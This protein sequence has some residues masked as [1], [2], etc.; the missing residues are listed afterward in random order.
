MAEN[1]ENIRLSAE[2]ISGGDQESSPFGFDFVIVGATGDLTM[3]KLLPAFYERFR[4]DQ[5]D[6]TT[7]IIGTARSPLSS[8]EYRTKAAEALKAFV[9]AETYDASKAEAFLRLLHYVPLDMTEQNADWSALS[10]LLK[11]EKGRP[12]V[13]YLATAPKLY[14][15]TADAIA[16]NSLITDTTRI[17]LEKPIGTDL[18]SA[19]AINDGVGQHFRENQIFRIDHYLGKQTVQNIL[20]LRFANPIIERIWNADSIAHVQITASETVGVGQRGSYY[21][22]AGALRDMVQNHLLQ[23]LSFVAMEPPTAIAPTVLRDE[24][25]KILRALRP[26]TDDMIRTDTVRAQYAAGEVDGT[27]VGSYLDDLEDGESTTETYLAIR[28]EIRTA[29][30]A[31]VPFYIR[32]GKRLAQKETTVIVQF[33]PQPWAIFPDKPEPGRLVIRIQPNEGISL[34]LSSKDPSTEQFCLREASLDVSYEKAFNTRY[35][36]SYEDLLMAAVRG[37]QVSFIRRDEVEAS[38]H[39]VEPILN[40]W[41]ANIRPLETYPAGSRGPKSA[42]D[43]LARNDFVWKELTDAC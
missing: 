39:W 12:R 31:G 20:A 13:F 1:R 36:D 33:R 28:A 43:L 19:T 37:D 7:K 6:G 30:W 25:L 10:S 9:A 2:E 14:V 41:A 38:W 15:P 27:T 4:G 40:G 32:T 17:V 34:S 26:M 16:H 5:I 42:D 21:D 35:P 3:R 24:K 23:V 8:E 18:A 11:T 29:R 22:T